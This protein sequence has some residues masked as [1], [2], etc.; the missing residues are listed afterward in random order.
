VNAK[1]PI[2]S[3]GASY[4]SH[5]EGRRSEVRANPEEGQPQPVLNADNSEMAGDPR[6][7]IPRTRGETLELMC[8]WIPLKLGADQSSR[9]EITS[10]VA[11]GAG[12]LTLF[13]AG[14]PG[15]EKYSHDDLVKGTIYH[16]KELGIAT[17]NPFARLRFY[18]DQARILTQVQVLPPSIASFHFSEFMLKFRGLDRLQ[19]W[20]DLELDKREQALEAARLVYDFVR[21][22]DRELA[23]K[24][25]VETEHGYFK[26]LPNDPLLFQVAAWSQSKS[27]V[28]VGESEIE[29]AVADTKE[30]IK[31]RS[32]ARE[33]AP[34]Q[35]SQNSVLSATRLRTDPSF[36]GKSA[37]RPGLNG[38][39]FERV[40]SGLL[41]RENIGRS[42]LRR[43]TEMAAHNFEASI[44]GLRTVFEEEWFMPNAMAQLPIGDAGLAAGLA[45][46]VEESASF[47]KAH[48]EY[49]ARLSAA[50]SQSIKQMEKDAR[51]YLDQD[52]KNNLHFAFAVP[53]PSEGASAI[54]NWLLD[55]LKAVQSLKTAFGDRVKADIRILARGAKLDSAFVKSIQRSGLAKIVE[56][57][58]NVGS[59]LNQF[60]GEHANALVFDLP[61]VMQG[62]IK[63]AYFGRLVRLENVLWENA[64]P[65]AT[66]I[67]FHAAQ[68]DQITA[69]LLN[70]IT[71]D[72]PENAVVFRNGQLVILEAVR[73][74]ILEA[75]AGKLLA[76]MA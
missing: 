74:L 37:P 11:F 10:D 65:I 57:D 15:D 45:A 23:D 47:R 68:V 29:A 6:K 20:P 71:R 44:A 39:V 52:P 61:S 14:F 43:F 30:R 55:Y 31:L 19:R 22:L 48:P 13:V 34:R 60:L 2:E 42:E 67:S 70:K 46:A 38:V 62:D 26:G 4:E 25:I 66:P 53:L 75:E 40:L 54:S 28:A 56:K 27:A 7:L 50:A 5:A 12:G 36:G 59:Q 1:D 8:Q 63:P 21:S 51:A 49:E 33:K 18:Y 24:I 9:M 17:A 16:N 58:G 32:E 3:L 41:K 35:P 69:D 64:F 73:Q 76:R 72:L